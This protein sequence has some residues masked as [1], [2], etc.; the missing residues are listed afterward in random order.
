MSRLLR[1]MVL[2]ALFIGI[3]WISESYAHEIL[4]IH[5]RACRT[6][7]ICGGLDRPLLMMRLLG[8]LLSF[9]LP[10]VVASYWRPPGAP[11]AAA[12]PVHPMTASTR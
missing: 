12:T 7:A 10:A 9:T 1:W 6:S 11:S 2:A 4:T 5:E 3:I 8:L